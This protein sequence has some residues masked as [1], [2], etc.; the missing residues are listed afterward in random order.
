M[1]C[2]APYLHEAE[3]SFTSENYFDIRKIVIKI[4]ISTFTLCICFDIQKIRA[5]PEV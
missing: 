2:P 3:S 4:N 5:I 1:L